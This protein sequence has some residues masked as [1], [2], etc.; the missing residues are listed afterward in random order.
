MHWLLNDIAMTRKSPLNAFKTLGHWLFSVYAAIVFKTYVRLKV[1]KESSLPDE[2]FIICSNHQSHLDAI[3]L[4]HI[5]CP[6][7]NRSAMI[8]AKD[9]WYDQKWRSALSQIFFNTIPITRKDMRAN[10]SL[11]ETT[12]RMR[13]F[14]SNKGKCV[15]ILPEGTRSRDDCI[16]SFKNGIVL[17]A[18]ECQ[19]PIIPVHIQGSG[20]LWPK[21]AL[22]IRPGTVKVTV[23]KPILPGQLTDAEMIRKQVIEL[24]N[25]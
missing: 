5:G 11:R 17:L 8:A 20:K 16:K 19:L 22:L 14:I 12:K 4:S 7:F 15:V 9:Y 1:R 2:P 13:S 6:N 3:I 24:S 25:S 18:R 21:G 10:M 23:G